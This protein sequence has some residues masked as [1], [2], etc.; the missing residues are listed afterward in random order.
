MELADSEA[1]GNIP[2]LSFFFLFFA[3]LKMGQ[4]IRFGRSGA[5]IT[6]RWKKYSTAFTPASIFEDFKGKCWL[7]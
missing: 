2:F 5:E 7:G 3:T 4:E 6:A 1:A